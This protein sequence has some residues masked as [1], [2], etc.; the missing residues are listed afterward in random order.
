MNHFVGVKELR[1]NF[2][3][4]EKQVQAGKSF[5]VLKRSKPIFQM[6]PVD[7]A[8]WETVVD[9][10]PLRKN[11]IPAEELLRTLGRMR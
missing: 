1:E 11:G 9:F 6:N 7:D 8:G 5:I 4:Y 10:R 3:V 2:G